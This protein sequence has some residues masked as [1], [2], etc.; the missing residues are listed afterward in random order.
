MFVAELLFKAQQPV[1]HRIE[2]GL[3]RVVLLN[4]GVE[5]VHHFAEDTAQR[6]IE[7]VDALAQ[8]LFQGIHGQDVFTFHG[9]TP[10]YRTG[11]ST[12]V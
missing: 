11:G 7:P 8:L 2:P 5:R 4:H 3:E 12:W 1:T 6:P 10:A 9:M